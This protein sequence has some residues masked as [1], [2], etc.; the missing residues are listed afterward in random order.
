MNSVFTAKLLQNLRNKKANK[1][2]TLIELLV[3]VIIIGVLAAVALPNLLGQV[4][5]ARE[6]EAKNGVGTINRAQ[7][8]YH[9]ERRTFSP[10]LD[11]TALA[12]QN[13]L[14]VILDS[15]YYTFDITAAGS[16]DDATVDASPVNAANDGVRAYSGGI[17]H[18]GGA[19]TTAVCQEVTI[20]D[21]LPTPTPGAA[22]PAGTNI[23]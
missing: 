7:Q 6:T 10:D 21:G 16:A 2:F 1:G 23:N 15:E 9:F 19:Y 14:G 20:G 12:G 4:G 13:A 3:V 22:C 8:A 5:K 11:D 18:N 17:N